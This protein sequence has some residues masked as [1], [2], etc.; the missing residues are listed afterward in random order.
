MTDHATRA[1]AEKLTKQAADLLDSI[2]AIDDTKRF[3]RDRRLGLIEAALEQAAQPVW[4]NKAPGVTGWFFHRETSESPY[5]PIEIVMAN[6]TGALQ[7]W[8]IDGSERRPL[9]W[10]HLSQEGEGW[11][12]G[13][14]FLKRC[15]H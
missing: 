5:R 3:Q 12:I 1:R 15:C 7:P 6:Y 8:V 9:A 13:G 11:Q 2:L 10:L 4:V 14:Q